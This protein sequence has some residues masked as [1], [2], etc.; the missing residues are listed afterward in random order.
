MTTTK[1]TMVALS[2][3]VGA[4]AGGTPNDPTDE[5][6]ITG[7][8]A[9][10]K[11]EAPRGGPIPTVGTP[12]GAL[13]WSQAGGGQG[14]DAPFAVA[15]D[16]NGNSYMAGYFANSMN[17]GCGPMT[18]LGAWDMYVAAYDAT[19]VC[20]WVTRAGNQ[21]G[22]AFATTLA[23]DATGN[24]YVGGG[25]SGAIDFG[26]PGTSFETTGDY[27]GFLAKYDTS[28][29]LV[30]A[31][32]FGGTGDEYPNAMATNG[33][34]VVITGGFTGT[35]VLGSNAPAIAS[36][37]E[38]DIYVAGYMASNG[39]YQWSKAWGNVHDDVG[40]AVAM[41]TA[42]IVVGGAYQD[43]LG[44]GGATL[45][46]AGFYDG[47]LV[48]LDLSGT[49]VSS[50]SIGGAGFDTVTSLALDSQSQ[51][52]VAAGYFSSSADVGAAAALTGAGAMTGF[53][54]RYG[55]SFSHTWSTAIDG[56]G[57][58]II[59]AV[60]VDSSGDVVIG[61]EFSGDC[62]L[63]MTSVATTDMLLAKLLGADGTKLWANQYGTSGNASASSVAIGT[64][65]R[66][67]TTG[68]FDNQ[69]TLAGPLPTSTNGGT[70][71]VMIAANP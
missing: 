18:A 69:I 46:N 29:A 39:L 37:G 11:A 62:S 49:Y 68:V 58:A 12:P 27:D 60:A 26:L 16:K 38:G 42:K 30:W 6:P 64:G 7:A 70:D 45:T 31:S 8:V 43:S 34:L 35:T 55:A 65:D 19:G 47:F 21:G 50:R 36:K 2:L 32:R 4:C 33:T 23:L 15:T 57:H 13:V 56:T 28:G 40:T 66:V 3:A 24:V 63:A 22:M 20:T 41:G 67:F 9:T 52:V 1:A 25:F 48:E 5:T 54:A 17:V 61:G 14:D 59:S 44:F 51:D 71:I 53:V 10:P